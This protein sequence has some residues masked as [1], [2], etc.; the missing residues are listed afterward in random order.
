[1]LI[2]VVLLLCFVWGTLHSVFMLFW[3]FPDTVAVSLRLFDYFCRD[4]AC[5]VRIVVLVGVFVFFCYR[6][7]HAASLL[8]K[9]VGRRFCFPFALIH[10]LRRFAP[11]PAC[12]RGTVCWRGEVS[13]FPF[14]TN[15][16]PETGASTPQGGG[17]GCFLSFRTLHA[18]SLLLKRVGRK[19]S[20][21]RFN[22]RLPCLN[23]RSLRTCVFASDYRRSNSRGS[24]PCT[25]GRVRVHMQDGPSCMASSRPVC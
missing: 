21:F 16:P 11:R 13:R 3:C 15:S 9:R 1:M 12:L 6:T 17:G 20:V 7:L 22:S 14:V 23:L 25:L 24:I 10:P 2:S 18:A 8:L 19:F 4:A 5:S